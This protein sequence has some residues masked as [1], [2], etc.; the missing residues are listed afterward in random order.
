MGRYTSSGHEAW[1]VNWKK[2]IQV[3]EL[4]WQ[5]SIG[6]SLSIPDSGSYW[7]NRNHELNRH[8]LWC[9]SVGKFYNNPSLHRSILCW[10]VCPHIDYYALIVS[11]A[12][13]YSVCSTHIL[14]QPLTHKMSYL[15][16]PI[17]SSMST[18]KNHLYQTLV[19]AYYVQSILNIVVYFSNE[20]LQ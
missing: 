11:I 12:T 9:V 17:E 10:H 15:D 14:W 20:Y 1:T 5:V 4:S 6:H 3:Y 18:K 7:Q 13:K 16:H 2:I 8:L 19:K